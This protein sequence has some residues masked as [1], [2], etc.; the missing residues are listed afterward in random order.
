MNR[1]LTGTVV[2]AIVAGFLVW[3]FHPNQILKRRTKGLMATLTLAEGAGAASRNLKIHPLSRAIA[4][5][6]RISGAGDRRAEGTF[7]RGQIE[8][9]FSWL[10]RNASHTRFQLRRVESVTIQ[11]S[12][13]VVRA[14]V[15][16]EVEL[17]Q[18][19]SPLQ[20]RQSVTLTWNN[21]ESSW[22][23]IAAEWNPQ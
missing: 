12:Q 17:K 14:I 6:V 20:G 18:H 2:L 10:T 13:G 3:W 22:Q 5:E 15:D 21:V 8:S 19:P 9:G 4:D 23:L 7:S 11:G 1:L 16:A